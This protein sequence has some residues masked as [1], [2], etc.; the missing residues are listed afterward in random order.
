[1]A[2]YIGT[3]PVPQA[4]QTR[5]IFTATAGQTVFNTQ[6]YTPGYVDVYLNGI[7]LVPVEDYQS[8]DGASIVLEA[9]ASAGDVIEV[10]AWTTFEVANGTGGAGA[11]GGGTD[12]VF[13]ENDTIISA[14]YTITSGKNA[15]TFGPVQI[16]DGVVVTIPD[17][18]TWT[19]V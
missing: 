4:T 5:D 8:A 15:G 7:H 1:M 17:G 16:A 9:S 2:G 10:V 19:V 3:Q 12:E 13:Y 14:N 6:G 18:S 11:T